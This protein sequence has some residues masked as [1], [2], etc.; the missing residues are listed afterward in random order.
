MY[1]KVPLFILILVVSLAPA[2]S[3]NAQ[4]K[5]A[6]SLD[7]STP[8][9]T[10]NNEVMFKGT[11]SSEKPGK[12]QYKFIR[13]DGKLLP[14]ETIE[15]SAPGTKEVS[16]KWT[17]NGSFQAE[18]KGWQAIKIV[19]PEDI[20]SAKA[21][22]DFICDPSKPDLAVR[23]KGCPAA[24]RPGSD[25]KSSVKIR[26]LNFG[27]VDIKDASVNIILKKDSACTLPLPQ[28][29]YSANYHDGVQLLGGLEK[30]SLKAGQKS[31]LKLRGSNTIPHDTPEG[32]YFVCAVID[33]GNNIKESNESNNC[34]CCPV[35]V[36]N[37]VAKPD[38][39]VERFAFK[40][41]GKCE[42]K[43][44]IMT[45]EVTVKNI[46]NASSPAMPD[47]AAVQVGDLDEKNWA[48]SAGL[49]SIPPGGRQTVVIPV[50]YNEKNP[51]HMLRA[52][53]HPF[54]AVI[55]PHSLLDEQSR[56]NNRS[57][58]IYLDPSSVCNK[59]NNP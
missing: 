57:D 33:A 42:P 12:V 22:F 6:F 30:V 27:G 2:V 55:D 54:R 16:S 25:L 45:F 38:L 50:Y 26:A 36:A 1:W 44:V 15:F 51:D 4:V 39:M 7:S 24:V 31:D 19:Y 11:I 43:N 8:S 53:P 10:C 59:E 48:N 37:I 5:A 47:K 49:N 41:W 40:G 20:E 34:A 32:D 28:A 58:I 18:N 23:I 3:S 13:S 14:V 46:G 29:V 9:G 17:L 21:E 56:K 35:K 52:I